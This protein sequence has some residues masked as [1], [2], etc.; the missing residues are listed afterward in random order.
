MGVPPGALAAGPGPTEASVRRRV[1]GVP[2]GLGVQD[3]RRGALRL[4][5]LEAFQL[6]GAPR[7][8]S[9]AHHLPGREADDT[10]LLVAVDAA[11]HG[12]RGVVRRRDDI[13][14]VDADRRRADETEEPGVPVP[15]DED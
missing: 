2:T 3:R 9:R 15:G 13:L 11:G 14:A 8:E 12:E 1:R 4:V 5:A 10:A 7:P 6:A